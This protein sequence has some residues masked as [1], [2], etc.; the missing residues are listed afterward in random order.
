M[1]YLFIGFVYY[2]FQQPTFFA[3]K[4][5]YA[6][7]SKCDAEAKSWATTEAAKEG[8]RETY[9]MC[10]EVTAPQAGVNIVSGDA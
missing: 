2:A 6:E 9:G 8:V 10:L 1:L 7:F 5:Y 4:N 3:S